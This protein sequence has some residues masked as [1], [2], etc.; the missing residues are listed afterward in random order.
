MDRATMQTVYDEI[1][2]LLNGDYR[3]ESWKEHRQV[4]GQLKCRLKAL[5]ETLNA[6]GG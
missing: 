5:E 6:T 4:L 3:D 2:G 1:D